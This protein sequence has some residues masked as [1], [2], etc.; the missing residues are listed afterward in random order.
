MMKAARWD[1]QDLT[2]QAAAALTGFLAALPDSQV[3]VVPAQ[4]A[5]IDTR[6]DL[7][8]QLLWQGCVNVL[9]VGLKS[10]L[11]PREARLAIAELREAS[12]REPGGY[13]VLMAPFLSPAVAELCVA[14]GVGYADLAGNCRLCFDRV[15]IER[16]G[17]PNPAPRQN[18]L[19]SLFTPRAQCIV[20][21]L[22][23]HPGRAWKLLELATEAGVSVGHV[24]SVKEL[25]VAQEWAATTVRG[26]VLTQPSALLEAWASHG[27]SPAATVQAFALGTVNELEHALATACEELGFPYALTE[28]SA[29]IRYAPMVRYVRA[30]AY[31]LGDLSAVLANMQAQEV[32]SGANL[33]LVRPRDEG[34]LYGSQTID[35]LRVVAPVQT[36]VD[37]MG[38]SG[39]G[40]E[41]AAALRERML[42]PSW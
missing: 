11:H 35:D 21:V 41:A 27:P 26:L 14:E 9:L 12:V 30:A 42:E 2:T 8:V 29:A 20:R 40:T 4:N 10:R 5:G 28:F 25:L 18:Q 34:V 32:T 1:E 37:L 39:R 17:H 13:P 31:V 36:Y 6:L 19:Q 3:T 15:F 23:V 33:K 24:H 38:L 22:L 7:V 16:V